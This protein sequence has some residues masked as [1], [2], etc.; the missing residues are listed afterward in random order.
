MS[1]KLNDHQ[2]LTLHDSFLNLSPRVQKIVKNSWCSDFAEIVFPAI[3]EARFAVL[4]NDNPASRPNTPVNFIIGAL[5]LK[6]TG[7]LSDDELLESICCDVRYQYALHSTHYKEQPVSDRTFS[8]FRERIYNYKLETGRDL[9]EEEME[10]L[11]QT[12]SKYMNLQSNMKRMDSLM[13]ASHCKS[14]SRLEII[15]Q[16]TANA[17]KLIDRLGRRDLLTQDLLHYLEEEDYNNIIY[18]C[19]G[20]DAEPR[21]QKAIREAEAVKGI[22][23]D[24]IWHETSEYQLLIRVLKEQTDCSEDG[25]NVPKNK[26][27]ISPSS[28]QNPSDPDATFRSKEGKSHKGYSTNIIETFGEEGSLITGIRVEPNTYSD[29]QF[30][31]DYIDQK[32]DDSPETMITDGAYG[33]TENQAFAEE[34]NIHLVPTCLT[35][36]DV[37]TIFAQFILNEEETQVVSC[38]MGHAPVKTTH[39]PKTG[40]CRALFTK[41]C[42]ENCPNKDACKAK[43]QKKNFAVHVSGKMVQRAKYKEKLSTEEYQKLTRMRNA[44]EGIPSVLRRRY[45]IDDIPTYGLLRITTFIQFKA[46]A[47]NFVKVRLYRRSHRGNCAIQPEIG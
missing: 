45:H 47:Y 4:Y 23:A 43:P 8:R 28:L 14:M 11:N 42:C 44:I 2:Q 3:D 13:V 40:M 36:P 6:E 10:N 22:M 15:Y 7:N 34:K 5:M 26:K 25:E 12:Y 38:P 24:D 39:Y 46:M 33:G 19:K 32:E 20:E 9:L 35:G 21:L 1:F 37:D 17:I 27:D 31:K 16:T 30:C 41:S 29:S 18:Y